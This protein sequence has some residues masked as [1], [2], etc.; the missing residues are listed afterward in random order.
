MMKK[1]ISLGF[2]LAVLGIWAG[3]PTSAYAINFHSEVAPITLSGSQNG[4]NVIGTTAGEV[5][6]STFNYSGTQSTKTASSLSLA[7]STSGCHALIFGSKIAASIDWNECSFEFTP[8]SWAHLR[9]PE[10]KDVVITVAGCSITI[11]PQL[12]AGTQWVLEKLEKAFTL[13]KSI[14]GMKY[15]H[16]G[17][18]CGTGSGTNG[19]FTGEDTI[20]A[21]SGLVWVE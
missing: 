7:P 11:T 19:T 3:I 16:S 10:G 15:S 21:S 12:V 5:T 1:A 14:K 17:F 20:S 13:I 4:V 6:C 2:I 9:C 8:A 18:T